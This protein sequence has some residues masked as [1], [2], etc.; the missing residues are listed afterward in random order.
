MPFLLLGCVS[1]FFPR[2][3][4]VLLWLF[5]DYLGRAF[6]TALWPVLGFIFAPFTV[7][8]YAVA[9]NQ[10]QMQGA[11]IGLVVLG[12]LLDLGVIG[13]GGKAAGRRPRR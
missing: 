4:I 5:S 3:V 2:V 10:G 9:Q 12:V 6:S 1:L 13:G 7:L 11:W 8:G